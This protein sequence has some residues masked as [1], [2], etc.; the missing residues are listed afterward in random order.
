M[1]LELDKAVFGR[2]TVKEIIGADP[3]IQDT[4]NLLEAVL[5]ELLARVESH[6]KER[7]REILEEQKAAHAHVNSRPGAMALAQGKIQLYN[8]YNE[9]YVRAVMARL[10]S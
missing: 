8:R 9:M 5:E 7:L 3:P 2:V 4:Q 1:S 10:G 6:P